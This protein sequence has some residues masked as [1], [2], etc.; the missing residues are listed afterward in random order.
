MLFLQTLETHFPT[1][2]GMQRSNRGYAVIPYLTP[3]TF[4]FAPTTYKLEA[5]EQALVRQETKTRKP[6][7][8]RRRS[9][10][11][12]SVAATLELLIVLIMWFV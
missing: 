11:P 1:M 4:P 12:D 3:Q 8:Q 6:S 2:L 9:R 10:N 7:P 5:S